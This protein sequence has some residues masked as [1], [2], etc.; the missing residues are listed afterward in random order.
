MRSV[1]LTAVVFAAIFVLVGCGSSYKQ[2]RIPN[3]IRRYYSDTVYVNASAEELLRQIGVYTIQAELQKMAI[4]TKGR[5]IDDV[6]F[7]RNQIETEDD[8]FSLFEM[9]GGLRVFVAPGRYK[10]DLPKTANWSMIQDL[11]TFDIELKKAVLAEHITESEL[12]KLMERGREKYNNGNYKGAQKDFFKAAIGRPG[13]DDA[14]MMYGSSLMQRRYGSRGPFCFCVAAS[15]VFEL[16]IDN[17]VAQSNIEIAMDTK[18]AVDE[19][20]RQWREMKARER[21]ES[22]EKWEQVAATMNAVAGALDATAQAYNAGSGNAGTGQGGSYGGGSSANCSSYQSRYDNA[23]SQRDGAAL[24]NA[25]RK[26][27]AKAKNIL[28][29]IDP[30]KHDAASAGDHRLIN[31]TNSNIRQ[32]DRMMDKIARDA[33]KAGCTVY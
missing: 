17:E 10:I 21:Q 12:A 16:L 18:D 27:S 8:G 14:V 20:R 33:R 25:G 2:K 29:D 13:S 28:H 32:Y 24:S 23:K 31:S 4:D 9:D 19:E 11:K 6:P 1:L 26:G 15:Q 5:S 30:E 22:A 7:E 3:S